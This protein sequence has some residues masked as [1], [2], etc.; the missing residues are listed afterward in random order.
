MRVATVV[1]QLCKSCRICFMFY[2]M[3]YFTCDRSLS[4]KWPGTDRTRREPPDVAGLQ[5]CS[6]PGR[7]NFRHPCWSLQRYSARL[8][9]PAPSTLR[10]RFLARPGRSI[11][12]PN[13]RRCFRS[14]LP[15]VTSTWLLS[16]V[17]RPPDYDIRYI[18]TTYPLTWCYT[19]PV[20]QTSDHCCYQPINRISQNMYTQLQKYI[21]QALLIWTQA[22]ISVH[23]C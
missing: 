3:F 4:W 12:A 14:I 19:S 11:C 22:L 9:T 5:P 7:C 1:Q 15:T 6:P 17:R 8:Q 18:S 10:L 16:K 21:I 2:R 13:T 23:M 20:R